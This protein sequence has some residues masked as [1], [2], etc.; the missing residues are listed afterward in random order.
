M[1]DEIPGPIQSFTGH[2]HTI[3]HTRIPTPLQNDMPVVHGS[4]SQCNKQFAHLPF[5]MYSI[6][7]KYYNVSRVKIGLRLNKCMICTVNT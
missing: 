1:T 5:G 6:A 3:G 4:F 2:S 7:I